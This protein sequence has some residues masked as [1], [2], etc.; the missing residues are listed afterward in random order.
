MTHVRTY[1]N[2]VD[3]IHALAAAQPGD[4]FVVQH[5]SYAE[6]AQMLIEDLG[7]T[8]IEV[9]L[10]VPEPAAAAAPSAIARPTTPEEA[11]RRRPSGTRDRH[12]HG[13]RPASL[14]RHDY[15]RRQRR[16]RELVPRPGPQA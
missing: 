8:R 16:A 5:R 11:F 12:V 2:L 1:E 4:V 7:K 9:R 13:G 15:G 6:I 3:F 14:R 10:E